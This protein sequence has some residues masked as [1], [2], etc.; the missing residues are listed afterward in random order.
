[1]RD[2]GDFHLFGTAVTLLGEGIRHDSDDDSFSFVDIPRS[3]VWQI[4]KSGRETQI[5]LG[6]EAAF[7]CKLGNGD[8]LAGCASGLFVDGN[9]LTR[10][11]WL[12]EAEALNDGAVHP[13]GK[14]LVFGSR[15]KEENEPIGSMWILGKQMTKLPWRFTVFNGPAF[16]PDGTRIYFTDSPAREIYVAPVNAGSQSI[17][18]REVF[19][20]VP[21]EFGFPDGMICDSEGFVWSAHWDGG[22]LT[23]YNAG[24][25][26]E[27]RISVPFKRPTSLA[28]RGERLYMT[29]ALCEVGVSRPGCVDGRLGHF[30]A[31]VKGPSSP[32]LDP[33]VL[34]TTRLESRNVEN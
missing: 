15:H 13:S 23:R 33:S 32:R 25:R 6:D 5:L 27:S 12:A 19:A 11:N 31:N 17:G 2:P 9:K 8:L 4:D 24:G 10:S 14:F 26:V 21:Q 16:S 1:M 20:V 30:H 22:C 34:D 28:F 29:S 3:R 7:V 18:E